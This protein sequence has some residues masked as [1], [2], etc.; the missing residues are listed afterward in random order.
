MTGSRSAIANWATALR[1]CC[2]TAGR[3]RATFGASD[4][5]AGVAYDFDLFEGA[6]DGLLDALGV[7]RLGLAVHDLGGPIGLHWTVRNPERVTRLALLNTLVYPQFAPSV[8][9]FVTTL[10]TPG[11]R[12]QATSPASDVDTVTSTWTSSTVARATSAV[13]PYD[14]MTVTPTNS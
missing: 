6:I 11:K 12:E 14:V 10:S 8:I 13:T 4:K 9:E 2:S 3:R 1:C 7:D 5:P